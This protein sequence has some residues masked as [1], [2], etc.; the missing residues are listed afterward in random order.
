MRMQVLKG[1]AE[2]HGLEKLFNVVDLETKKDIGE[3][4]LFCRLAR[5][6][7]FKVRVNSA[8]KVGHAGAVMTPDN[9]RAM[10]GWQK[11]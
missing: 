1:L 5:R 8:I 10:K 9:F 3:D 4:M 11:Q 6:E 2:K 7:G